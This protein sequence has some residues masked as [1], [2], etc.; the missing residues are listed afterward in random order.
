M[1][2]NGTQLKFVTRK[3]LMAICYLTIKDITVFRFSWN[4]T[5]SLA[6]VDDR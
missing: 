1:L 3:T 2:W 6:K 5:M 4:L